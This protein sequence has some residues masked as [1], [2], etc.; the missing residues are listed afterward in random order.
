MSFSC[1]Y[2]QN[3][4]RLPY[5][6]LVTSHAFHANRSFLPRLIESQSKIPTVPTLFDGLIPLFLIMLQR[7]KTDLKMVKFLS[8]C[9]R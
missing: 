6:L 5:L 4:P 1:G 8:I 9:H 2:L 3:L 7:N